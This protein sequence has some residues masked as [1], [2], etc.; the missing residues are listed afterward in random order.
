MIL[1]LKIM[2]WCLFCVGMWVIIEAV[3]AAWK[4]ARWGYEQ[5]GGKES[6]GQGRQVVSQADFE[7][8]CEGAGAQR[9]GV[10]CYVAGRRYGSARLRNR[11]T[12]R[13][14]IEGNEWRGA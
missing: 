7:G 8:V 13:E 12:V 11:R 14:C 4:G 6:E 1:W 10:E 3:V 5:I 9:G 2:A